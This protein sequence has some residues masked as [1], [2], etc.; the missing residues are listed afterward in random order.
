VRRATMW[1]STDNQRNSYVL[2]EYLLHALDQATVH[3]NTVS[4]ISR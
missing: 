1:Q 4:T 2:L 3:K